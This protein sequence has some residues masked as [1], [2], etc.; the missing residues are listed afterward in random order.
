MLDTGIRNELSG[1]LERCHIDEA[2]K[3]HA[4]II[5]FIETESRQPHGRRKYQFKLLT[6]SADDAA[7]DSP[8]TWLSLAQ[9]THV[10]L[11]PKYTKH[12]SN[13]SRPITRRR[14]ALSYYAS[15]LPSS[16]LFRAF[17]SPVSA[18]STNLA[19]RTARIDRISGTITVMT[20]S[21]EY[22]KHS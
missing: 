3:A 15:Y 12:L 18:K 6:S 20:A 5:L 9:N 14:W 10:L 22:S 16:N 19:T 17:P 2:Y 1:E 4:I 13:C 7:H 21:R 11:W 8:H